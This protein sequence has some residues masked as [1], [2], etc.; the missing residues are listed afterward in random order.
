MEFKEFVSTVQKQYNKMS[1]ST[2][3]T[4]D[5]TK[6]ELWSHYIKSFP[7]EYNKVL[8]SDRKYDCNQCRKFIKAIAG[9]VSI[10]NGELVS[11]WDVIAEG[12]YQD[13]ANSMSNLVKSKKI[14]NKFMI[15]PDITANKIVG[16][17]KNTVKPDNKTEFKEKI[18]MTFYHFNVEVDSA[19]INI[20]TPTILS[21]VYSKF[22]SYK[23][24]CE[25]ITISSIETVKDLINRDLY[26]GPEFLES[27]I[28][29]ESL[30]KGYNKA[31]NKNLYLWSTLDGDN[32]KIRS[33]VIGTLLMDVATEDLE[34]AVEKFESKVA[35]NKYKRT[36]AIVTPLMEK[37]ALK[38]I[39]E[40]GIE[41]SLYKRYATLSDVSVNNVV[42]VDRKASP[43]MLDGIAGLM[44]KGVTT[45][46]N[47]GKVRA[48]ITLDEFITNVIPKTTDLSLLLE[49]KNIPNMVSLVA[50]KYDNTKNIQSWNNNFSWAYKGGNTDSMKSRVKEAGG[51][52]DGILRFSLQ[53]NE[54]RL[55]PSNDLDAHCKAPEGHIYYSNKMGRLDVDILNPDDKTAVE[56]ITWLNMEDLQDGTYS[57]YV[58]NFAGTNRKG[59]RAEV[60]IDGEV[61]SYE[62]N[63]SVRSNA[64]VDVARVT[65]KDGKFTIINCLDSSVLSKEVWGI[66]TQELV[67]VNSIMYSPNFWNNNKIGQKHT[68]FMLDGCTNP[69]EIRGLFNEHLNPKY[70]SI[71]KS[72]DM[73]SS[74]VK[75]KQTDNQISGIGV[76]SRRDVL[77]LVVRGDGVGGTYKVST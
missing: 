13:V 6:D 41:E 58:H 55:D 61:H 17:L 65:L 43:K 53:W 51:N 48:N 28:E 12:Y 39:K 60:E 70:R 66:K 69:N 35:P 7:S 76:G 63:K 77:I 56:N 40:E 68:F 42:Y 49:N 47:L 52:V 8:F 19:L 9:V 62:Y 34:V 29:F 64:D 73:L 20:D 3:Y 30:L 45:K 2:L 31:K 71:R 74:M 50:P 14:H 36:N 38:V 24:S 44:K 25:D 37:E 59:F 72:I 18:G 4:V 27:V 16:G 15:K 54:D 75:C 5:L 57:F 22:N 21:K 33:T 46:L 23:K 1:K 32:R 26:R 11:I 67:K 10:E